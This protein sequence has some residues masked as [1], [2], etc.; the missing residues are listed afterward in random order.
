LYRVDLTGTKLAG[1]N[2]TDTKLQTARYDSTTLWPE[3]FNYRSSGAIG[4]AANLNGAVLNTSSFRHV[5]LSGAS[6]L[7]AYLGGA[8]L[9]GA[10][11]QNARLSQADLRKAFFTGASLRGARLNGANV[12]GVDFR[13]VDFTGVEFDSLESIGGADFAS[14]IGLTDSQRRYLLSHSEIELDTWNNFTRRTTR[15][16]LK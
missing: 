3:G 5:D 13:A 10:N 11:L 14:S 7:G 4:P 15:Q 1:V 16:S 9:T 12:A 8:D 2:L 6:L